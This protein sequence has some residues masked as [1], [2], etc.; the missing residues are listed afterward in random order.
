MPSN[1]V[2]EQAADNI[3]TVSADLFTMRCQSRPIEALCDRVK[4]IITAD[5]LPSFALRA[6]LLD[7]FIDWPQSEPSLLPQRYLVMCS[8]MTYEKCTRKTGG[9]AR[10]V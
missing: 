4:G 7:F 9:A 3:A 6:P 1:L 10:V 5:R 2:R 8:A